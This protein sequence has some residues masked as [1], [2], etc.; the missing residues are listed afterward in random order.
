MGYSL[1]CGLW[2]WRRRTN[3]RPCCPRMSNLST[4]SWTARSFPSMKIVYWVNVCFFCALGACNCAAM[5]TH[6]QCSVP[7]G[8]WITHAVLI[9][10]VAR[11]REWDSTA[12]IVWWYCAFAQSRTSEGILK[13]RPDGSGWWHNWM[14]AQRLPRDLVRPSSVS[15]ELAQTTTSQKTHNIDVAMT[16]AVY[17]APF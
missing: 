3:R 16:H 8:L 12:Q 9:W 2:V 10:N 13:A 14:T 5:Q 17:V 11:A 4:S 15:E 6:K 7:I 1:L